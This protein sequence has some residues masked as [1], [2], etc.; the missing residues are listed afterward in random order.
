VLAQFSDTGFQEALALY[1]AMPARQVKTL[2]MTLDED[3]VTRFLHAMQP[4]TAT[5]IIKEFKAPDEHDRIQKILE[6]LRQS[7]LTSAQR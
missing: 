6:K 5:K 4:R 7:Q 1:Q 2:F 3:V